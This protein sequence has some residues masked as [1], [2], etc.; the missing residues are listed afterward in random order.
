VNVMRRS[1]GS[2][3]FEITP[4]DVNAMTLSLS[5]QRGE[6]R[7]EGWFGSISSI[8]IYASRLITPHPHSL[9]PLRGEGGAVS[10][11]SQFGKSVS[12]L[13]NYL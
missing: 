4:H 13:E 9:S 5:P 10:R 2:T 1:N 3:K 6:G 7:G 8:P 12:I 11:V